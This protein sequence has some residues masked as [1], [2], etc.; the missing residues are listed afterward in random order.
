[1]EWGNLSTKSKRAPKMIS[2]IYDTVQ[3]AMGSWLFVFVIFFCVFVLPRLPESRAKAEA[4]R[5]LEVQGEN[6]AYCEKWGFSRGTSKY[7]ECVLDLQGLRAKI[8]QR[9][10]EDVFP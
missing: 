6:S 10:S 4:A 5:I 2:T 8:E 7:Q 9:S 3:L 1:M